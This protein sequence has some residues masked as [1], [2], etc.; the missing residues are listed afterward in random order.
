M[1]FK[2]S[3]AFT[4]AAHR[5]HTCN[6]LCGQ[7]LATTVPNTDTGFSQNALRKDDILLVRGSVICLFGFE[8]GVDVCRKVKILRRLI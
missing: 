5:K 1:K 4:V 7:V 2:A 6:L 3:F 8:V